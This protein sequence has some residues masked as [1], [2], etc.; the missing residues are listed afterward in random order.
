[1]ISW[2]FW[3]VLSKSTGNLTQNLVEAHR[4]KGVAITAFG[5]VVSFKVIMSIL[6]DF[7][8]SFDDLQILLKRVLGQHNVAQLRWGQPVGSRVEQNLVPRF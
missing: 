4:A 3:P 6:Q 8:D 7:G 2:C 1:M 5:G